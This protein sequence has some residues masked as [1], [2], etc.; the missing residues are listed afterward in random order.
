MFFAFYWSFIVAVKILTF[1][2]R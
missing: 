1:C 2:S